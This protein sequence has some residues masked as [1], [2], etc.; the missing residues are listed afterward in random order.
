MPDPLEV[1]EKQIEKLRAENAKLEEETIR[2][3]SELEN[4]RDH[5]IKVGRKLNAEVEKEKL[6]VSNL[7][8]S[9]RVNS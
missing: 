1:A 2:L 5:T 3:Q 4:E 9:I 6:L 8:D 7:K